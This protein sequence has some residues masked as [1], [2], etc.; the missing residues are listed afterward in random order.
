MYHCIDR[1]GNRWCL[2]RYR[3]R[4]RCLHPTPVRQQCPPHSILHQPFLQVSAVEN[5]NS[6]SSQIPLPSTALSNLVILISNCDPSPELIST[7]LS[8][9][10]HSLYSL[11]FH[12]SSQKTADPQLKESVQGLLVTWGKIVD[13]S[14]ALDLLWSLIQNGQRQY[15]ETDLDGSIRLVPE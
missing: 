11:L 15:W 4:P 2:L 5:V 3:S 10:V 12:L 14:K 8:P 1:R 9:I 6:K 7:L 13:A